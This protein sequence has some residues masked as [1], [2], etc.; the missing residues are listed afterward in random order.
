MT[1]KEF[2]SCN[3][4]N[5]KFYLI[6]NIVSN[7]TF[8]EPFWKSGFEV[9]SLNSVPNEIVDKN[10]IKHWKEDEYLVIIWKNE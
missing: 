6:P 7:Q 5:K 2:I 4:G 3:K 10:V 9:S 8:S 1:I